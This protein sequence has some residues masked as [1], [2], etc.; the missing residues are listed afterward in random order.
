MFCSWL[1]AY[2]TYKFN[3]IGRP[4]AP[5]DV[6]SRVIGSDIDNSTAT[7]VH[8]SWNG[9]TEVAT[10]HLYKTDSEGNV[11]N[12]NPV[13]ILPRTGFETALTYQ[14]FAAYVLVEAVDRYGTLLGRS[15]TVKSIVSAKL[16]P[17]TV[18]RESEWLEKMHQR[19]EVARQAVWLI[20]RMY[21]NPSLSFGLGLL[22]GITIVFA[23]RGFW[24]AKRKGYF[25]RQRGD[26]LYATVHSVGEVEKGRIA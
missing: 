20:S 17:L 23:T 2:R 19:A 7:L 26:S 1:K 24:Q 13:V 6:H 14:G 10:W 9:A 8:V 4:T 12:T 16:S 15:E 5:P 11:D 25:T 22:C 3:F 21:A 18:A